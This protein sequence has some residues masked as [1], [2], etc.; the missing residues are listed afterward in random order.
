MSLKEGMKKEL[1]R[2]GNFHGPRVV[3]VAADGKRVECH[4]LELNSLACAFTSLAVEDSALIAANVD[5]LK[6]VSQR[7]AARLTYLL[8]PIH[9]IEV[10][11]D[12][13]VVQLR[14]NPPH[15]D[16]DRTSYYEL[17][18]RRPGTISLMRYGKQTGEARQPIPAHVTREVLLRLVD[19]LSHASGA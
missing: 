1:D 4:L 12:Q 14:S 11:A 2:L 9:P 6:Q 17:L 18:V 15:R 13:C 3:H 10:D 19:D 5:Q 16:D 7:L 8:E